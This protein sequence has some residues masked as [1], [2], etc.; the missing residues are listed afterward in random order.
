[1]TAQ[2]RSPTIPL[3]PR[4]AT[5]AKDGRLTNCYSE[6]NEYGVAVVKRPG[7]S[8]QAATGVGC[9]QGSITYNGGAVF[10]K[11]DTL[12]I[13]FQPVSNGASW[14]G[15]TAPP[16]PTAN[17]V[18]G[19]TKPGY[20]V[21]HSGTLYHI[22]GKN[23]ADTNISVYQSTDNGTSWTTILTTAPFAGSLLI[24][25]Q[26]A[27]S[28]NGRIYVLLNTN[29]VWSSADGVSWVQNTADLSSGST[30]T[31]Q[32]LIIHNN[33]LY[34]FLGVFNSTMTIFSSPDG[35]TWTS[36]NGGIAGLGTRTRSTFYSMAGVL[37]LAAGWDGGVSVVNDVWRSVN[38]GA[39]WT[40]ITASAA[41]S[42]RQ[43]AQGWVY[44]DFLWIAGGGTNLGL[45]S[46]EDDVYKS[47][48][49]ITWTSVTG[50]AGW[51]ARYGASCCVHADLMYL[52]P[53]LG[54]SGS[55]TVAVSS[56]HKSTPGSATNAT[57]TSPTQNCLPMQ[58]ALIPANGSE[59][60][61][62]F[63]K[64]T[65]DAWVYDGTAITKVTDSDYPATTVY[66]VA[67]LDGTIYVMDA[68][69]VIYGSDLLTPL[70][71]SAL[72]F[73][74]ANAE[75]DAGVAIA[76]QL[77]NIIAFKDSS[78]EFFY[79]AANPTGSPLAKMPN[80]LL[81][82]G[83]A[84]AFS[85]AYSDNTIFFMSQHKQKGRS[86]MKFEGTT[87]SVVSTPF[88]DRVLDGDDLD[89]IYA[90]VVRLNGHVFYFLTLK[91][92]LK[93][94]VYDDTT[95]QWFT[96]TKLSAQP[97]AT[98]ST[99]AVQTDGSILVAMPLAHGAA[100]G[101]HVVITGATPSA[102]NGSFNL[103]YDTSAHAATQFSY[104]PDSAVSGSITGSVTATFYTSSYFPGAY[105][106]RGTNID[107][108]LDEA[109]GDVYKLDTTLAQDNGAP[110]DMHIRTE[111][112]DLGTINPKTYNSLAIVGDNVSSK[113]VVRYTNDDYA[114][115]G[116]YRLVDLSKKRP[117]LTQLGSAE[118]R[119]W[120]IRHTMN[121]QFRITALEPDI[122][123][124]GR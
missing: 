62:A 82:V 46:V 120:E 6:T 102:A 63:I 33:L 94:L 14:S 68:K 11:N 69:G 20:L 96:A 21:S 84:S 92:S 117:R 108:V 104:V 64:S 51:T 112:E 119:A 71:W 39:A 93:T 17:D 103:R 87:P 85:I 59:P 88:I 77:D 43:F 40:Q 27:V 113:C 16:K 100:D 1:M 109:T 47:T 48:D 54:R 116:K 52:G 61:K 7:Y 72:N 73:I 105:Y 31:G 111:R 45:T 121:T 123:G 9:A 13:N 81:E 28:F 25:S 19:T 67:Y 80:A 107:L 36:V 99:I 97:A 50:A 34:A 56:L 37:Y 76:R 122:D 98:V 83:C 86:I 4:D 110:I 95:K 75:A 114:T 10:F 53:G 57:L 3:V 65:K 118:R 24:A 35:I 74:S 49:G 12:M 58:A 60:T 106:A 44:D 2:R 101:D 5:A 23:N 78:I 42:A 18:A 91:T 26:A 15:L 124:W 79:D 89:T 115:F 8:L 30:R 70:A 55:N 66:G 32:G 22:G 38:N 90:F 41:F 29:A